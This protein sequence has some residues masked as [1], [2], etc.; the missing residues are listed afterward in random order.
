[1]LIIQRRPGEAILVAN[2]IEIT[3]IEVSPSRVKL[4]IAAPPYI[5]VFRKETKAARAQNRLAALTTHTPTDLSELLSGI[6]SRMPAGEPNT[7]FKDPEL[8][9][10]KSLRS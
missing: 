5:E 4:G 1:M 3:V 6:R 10:D 7:F 2:E 8:P 9:S